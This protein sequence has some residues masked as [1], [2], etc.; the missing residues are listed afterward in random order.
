MAVDSKHKQYEKFAT[1]WEKLRHVNEGQRAVHDAGEMYLPKLS[2]QSNE[3]YKAYKGRALFYEAFG[4]TVQALK[5][6]VFR[7]PPMVEANGQKAFVEDVTMGDYSLNEFAGKVVNELLV[8]GRVGVLVDYPQTQVEDLTIA[9][10]QQLGLQPFFTMY[11]AESIINWRGGKVLQEVRLMECVTK[12]DPE[13]EFNNIETKQIRVLDIDEAGAYRQRIY[14]LVEDGGKKEWQQLGEDFYPLM[15]GSKMDYIPF[16]FCSD[17]GLGPNV[18]C[19]PL[20]GLA[21]ANI[22]HYLSSADI[23]HGAHYTALPTAVVI[24]YS[25]ENADPFVIGSNNAWVLPD[26]ESD[27]KFLEFTGQGLSALETRIDKKEQIMAALGAQLITTEQRRNEAVETAQLRH[28][29]E[30]SVLADI[31]HNVSKMLNLC[32]EVAAA[33]QGINTPAVIELNT[34]FMPASMEPAYLR[35]LLKALQANAISYSTFF[36]E[37]KKGEII[38]GDKPIEEEVA[39]IQTQVDPAL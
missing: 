21:N 37:L 16:Y 8:S 11:N 14:V 36:N 22:S 27:V 10:A 2:G 39:E 5:G 38:D 7:K 17:K 32:L 13:D 6:M 23:E 15:N 12:V 28:N 29:G 26:A 25:D 9:D 30:H 19:P 20:L 18:S 4:R 35:E 3:E 34:D 1:E 24:G 33:W 31:A